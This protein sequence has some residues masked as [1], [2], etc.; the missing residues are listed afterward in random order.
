MSS[1]ELLSLSILFSAVC[2]VSMVFSGVRVTRSLVLY[3][4]CC[5]LLIVLLFSFCWPLCCLFLDTDSDY[6]FA[7]FKLVLS[8]IMKKGKKP[9]IPHRQNISKIQWKRSWKEATSIPLNT[10]IHAHSLS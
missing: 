4:I 10:Q 5:R 3:V 8:N 1:L 2:G 6:S 9:A 7:I